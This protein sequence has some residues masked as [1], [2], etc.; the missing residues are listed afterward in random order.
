MIARAAEHIVPA[1]AKKSHVFAHIK[2]CDPCKCGKL[3]VSNFKVLRKCVDETDC[4]IAEA[5][6]IKKDR[7]V[8]NKQLFA[9]GTSLTLRVWK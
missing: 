7:P 3:N 5:F 1:L 4:K 2:N 6:A 8:I 9:Q